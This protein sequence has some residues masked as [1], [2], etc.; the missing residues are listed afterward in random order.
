MSF[1]VVLA[2]AGGGVVLVRH[3]ARGWELPGGRI[4]AGESPAQAAQREFLEETGRR[5]TLIA[6]RPFKEGWAFAAIPGPA[7]RR[8]GGLRRRHPLPAAEFATLPADLAFPEAEL[9]RLLAWARHT[10]EGRRS[11]TPQGL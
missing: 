10:L 8:R 11:S 5:C 2:L 9:T 6:Q 3:P 7:Q 1:V 4:E